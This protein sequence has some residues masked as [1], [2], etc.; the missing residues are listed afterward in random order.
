MSVPILLSQDLNPYIVLGSTVLPFTIYA[1][2]YHFLIT[3]RRKKR[4]AK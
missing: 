1:A 4:L 2:A 3:P